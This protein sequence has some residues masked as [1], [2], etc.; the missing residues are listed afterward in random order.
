MMKPPLLCAALTLLLFGC[1]QS[2]TQCRNS[3]TGEVGCDGDA[4]SDADAPAESGQACAPLPHDTGVSGSN[5]SKIFYYD[6]APLGTDGPQQAK[7]ACAATSPTASCLQVGCDPAD[8]LFVVN[9][10][11]DAHAARGDAICASNANGSGFQ[12]CWFYDD[13]TLGAGNR[14]HSVSMGTCASSSITWN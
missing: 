13:G 2:S 12:W 9:Y 10:Q 5:G 8:T 11:V 1:G 14:A 3:K 4:G 7:E 6:C